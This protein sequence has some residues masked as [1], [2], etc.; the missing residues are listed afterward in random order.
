MNSLLLPD[1]PIQGV[2]GLAEE[3][4]AADPG[5][6]VDSRFALGVM[7]G[8]DLSSIG[9]SDYRSPGF[10]LGLNLEYY[11]IP[12]LTINGGAIIGTKKYMA[13]GR[14]YGKGR[15][16]WTRGVVPDTTM[17]QCT[18]LDIPINLRYYP[19]GGKRHKLFL[20]S[21]IS[22]YIFLTENYEFIYEMNAPDLIQGWNGKNEVQN[23]FGILNL[24]L[25]Y[26]LALPN[27]FF[28]QVEPYFKLPLAKVG[29]GNVDLM[30]TGVFFTAK[31]RFR[32]RGQ[33][34]DNQ[35]E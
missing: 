15:G 9:L 2:E 20:S 13:K 25:G 33:I 5:K 31:Y 19:L 4:I 18:V 11:I 7:L 29:F 3:S 22:S 32:K 24:S 14:E 27:N 21:G 6:A 28:L 30:T 26:Q 35:A 17:G 16:L 8:P 10:N 1:P 34:I 23:Y 12:K